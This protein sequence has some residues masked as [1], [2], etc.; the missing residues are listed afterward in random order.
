MS[1]IDLTIAL[2]A[3]LAAFVSAI[4]H[5]VGGVAGGL[6]LAICLAPLIGVKESVPVTAVAMIIANFNRVWLFRHHL[7]VGAFLAIFSTSLPLIVLSAVIY[8]VL[9]LGAV[10]L[11]LGLFLIAAVPLRR[12]MNTRKYQVGHK[13]LAMVG[14]VYGLVSGSTFGAGLLLAPFAGVQGV[15]LVATVAAIGLSLNLTKTLVFGMSP[16]L[17]WPLFVKG[18]LV[19][20]CTIPG[21]Y[22]GRWIVLNTPIRIHTVFMEVLI[23]LGSVYFLWGAFEQYG[24][25]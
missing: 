7:D 18:V 12:Y 24:W 23:I 19:G 22:V 6:L 13:G 14:P 11:I 17:D 8:V 5:A 1:D 10:A 4:F 2:L 15:R 3:V 25:V 20:L 16:L 21:T 9:P